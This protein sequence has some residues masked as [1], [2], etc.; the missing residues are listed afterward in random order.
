MKR[1]FLFGIA[2]LLLACGCRKH[3]AQEPVTSARSVTHGESY[4][5][6]Q[7]GGVGNVTN[8]VYGVIKILSEHT[9]IGPKP[10]SY[11]DRVI[12]EEAARA[13]F[14]VKGAGVVLFEKG[15]MFVVTA[16]HVIVPNAGLRKIQDKENTKKTTEFSKVTDLQSRVSIG[17]LSVSPEVV[18]LSTSSDLAVMSVAARDQKAVLDSFFRDPAAPID[19]YTPA[20][21]LPGSEVEAWGFPAKYTPQLEKAFASSVGANDIVVNKCLG[22][23]FSG[24][25]V[26]V[27]Q[28]PHKLPA[29]IVVRADEH[30]NQSIVIPWQQ[31]LETLRVASGEKTDGAV[32]KAEIDKPVD[33]EL[34]RYCLKGYYDSAK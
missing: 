11:L 20:V 29:G 27:S 34:T 15:R 19:L 18:F 22:R 14:V 30:D 2:A 26:L 21:V 5:L 24:G 4:T 7:T 9:L 31:V 1:I 25:I 32:V 28:P 10:K 23:G 3:Q 16:K 12:K 17:S 6:I 33:L 13:S 8:G